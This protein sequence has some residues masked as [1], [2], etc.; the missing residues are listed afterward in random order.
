MLDIDR[1]RRWALGDLVS[2]ANRGVFGEWL[3]GQ[4]LGV[5]GEEEVRREWTAF[6]LRYKDV[7]VE[8]KTTGR[9]QR[10]NRFE[11]SKRPSFDI[12]PRKWAWDGERDEW[13]EFSPPERPAQLYVF[14]LH[15]PVPA[16]NENVLDPGFWRFWVIPTSTLN[17]RLGSQKT[18]GLGTLNRL[19]E[20]VGCVRWAELKAAVDQ[21]IDTK[22]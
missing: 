22:R 4:A 6:D 12:A 19:T 5:I 2:N 17:E 18:V 14:C 11:R 15:K 3:V 13:V 7:L 20:P 9:S 21:S 16:T 1:F 8:V 10:W